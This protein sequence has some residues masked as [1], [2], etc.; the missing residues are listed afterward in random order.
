MSQPDIERDRL[1][2]EMHSDVKHL[3]KNFDTHILDDKEA[4]KSIRGQL[5]W[6]N[7]IVFI[8]IGGLAVLKY[9]IK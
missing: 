9:F 8:G 4:F 3:V 5:Q 6:V 2:S 1:I 7:R